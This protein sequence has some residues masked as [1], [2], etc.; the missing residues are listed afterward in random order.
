[1]TVDNLQNDF[2]MVEGK[3]YSDGLAWIFLNNYYNDLIERIQTTS[4]NVNVACNVR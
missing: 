4:E 3:W 2:I 1:M